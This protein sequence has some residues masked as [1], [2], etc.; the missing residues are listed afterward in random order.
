MLLIRRS[1]PTSSAR[2]LQHRHSEQEQ[3]TNTSKG[4]SSDASCCPSCLSV[5]IVQTTTGSCSSHIP[6]NLTL[7]TV[8]APLYRCCCC[9]YSGSSIAKT[10]QAVATTKIRGFML[11]RL[12]TFGKMLNQVSLGQD[13]TGPAILADSLPLYCTSR[14]TFGDICTNGKL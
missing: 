10:P 3:S 8:Q 11:H 14:M 13:G 6:D 4:P 12:S 9:C 2:V 5:G 7:E 1:S